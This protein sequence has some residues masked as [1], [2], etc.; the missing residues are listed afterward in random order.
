M[1]RAPL[2]LLLGFVLIHRSGQQDSVPNPA[3]LNVR[4]AGV[5]VT[6]QV[7]M[8]VEVVLHQGIFI[9][10]VTGITTLGNAVSSKDGCA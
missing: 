9:L 1:V 3:A 6:A 7:Q 2:H 10:G 8:G 4:K 5:R